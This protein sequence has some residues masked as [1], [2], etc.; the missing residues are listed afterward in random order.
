MACRYIF[1]CSAGH[2][3]STLLDLL[4]GAAGNGVSL[5]EI[6]QLPK[7]IALDS[8][9][10][11]G[12]KVSGCLFW[13]PAL[14]EFSSRKGLDLWTAPYELDLG[15]IK[16]GD[17]IDRA[18]QTAARMSA[19]K[20]SYGMQFAA[21]SIGLPGFAPGAAR[22]LAAAHNKV[23]LFDFILDRTAADYVVDSSKH[24]LEAL[25]LY[26][27]APEATA[28][29][30]LLRDGRA[31]MNS[32]LKRNMDP[33]A[34]LSTWSRHWARAERVLLNNLP[35]AN[36]HR[37]RYEELVSSHETVLQRLLSDLGLE[38]TQDPGR[39]SN[40]ERHVLNGNRMRFVKD[41]EVI[42][43]ESWRRNL[44]EGMLAFFDRHAG[45]LNRHLGYD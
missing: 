43:D 42:A 33:H 28:I 24:Y 6:T 25:Q 11:C 9:C 13:Q 18:N 36:L 7:N 35:S 17:E 34:A 16:A 32:G 31:V 38:S 12:E 14:T 3:G 29:V 45:K 20:L 1:I 41:L 15:F 4:L 10:S 5:G 2:S 19:R 30:L 21:A 40:R 44:D 39:H 26:R 8:T 23:E 27:A 22:A 37:V